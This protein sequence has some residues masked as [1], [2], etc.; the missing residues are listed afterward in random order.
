MLISRKLLEIELYRFHFWR[1]CFFELFEAEIHFFPIFFLPKFRL[2]I[3]ISW[4]FNFTLDNFFWSWTYHIHQKNET[5]T[6]SQ[7]TLT[8]FHSITE[9]SKNANEFHRTKVWVSQKKVKINYDPHQKRKTTTWTKFNFWS[10]T[11]NQQI[12]EDFLVWIYKL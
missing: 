10:G 2:R 5:Q 6:I 1:L 9:K 7:K 12:P 3:E 8:S 4:G 11:K